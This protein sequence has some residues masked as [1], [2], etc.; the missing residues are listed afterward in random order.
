[1]IGKYV[2]FILLI[3]LKKLNFQAFQDNL[4]KKILEKNKG[5]NIMFSPFSIYQI[6]SLLSNWAKENTQKEI[7]KVLF[8]DKKPNEDLINKIN[9][10][11]N[12]IISNIES[13]DSKTSKTN[14]YCI[15]GEDNC[16]IIFKDV[17]GI[18]IKKDVKLTNYFT[19]KCENYNASFFELINA[20]QIN[21]YCSENTNGKINK[22][23]DEIDPRT[24]LMLINAI[25]FKGIW[26]TKFDESSTKKS[27][28]KFW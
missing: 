6:L 28:W 2:T 7:L 5:K 26:V 20:E 11:I 14:D 9:S 24:V 16:K 1:M 13:E 22:I 10:N 17:N 4:F 18:F 3:T 15:K 12:Q 23:I 25:Y 8:P 19:E 27:F 21:N